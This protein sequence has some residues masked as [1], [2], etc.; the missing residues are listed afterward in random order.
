MIYKYL[1]KKVNR[2]GKHFTTEEIVDTLRS[3]NFLSITGEGYVPTYTR[4]DLTNNLHGSA[5][6]RMD[7]QIVTKQKMRSII[8]QTKKREKD[9]ENDV[10]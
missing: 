8:A 5:G 6:F 1:E 3:M 9:D 10:R 4:T 2:G 7:T